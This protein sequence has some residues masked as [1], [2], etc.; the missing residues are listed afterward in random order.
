MN[1][2][3]N[4]KIWRSVGSSVEAQLATRD[5]ETYYHRRRVRDPFYGWKWTAWQVT[6]I[7]PNL[8]S[9]GL[10]DALW[11]ETQS[12]WIPDFTNAKVRLPKTLPES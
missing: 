8:T 1:K 6:N 5:G 7:R 3:N 9:N 4:T 10:D 12:G 11:G 2:A